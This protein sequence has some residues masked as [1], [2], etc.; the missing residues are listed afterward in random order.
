MGLSCGA[1]DAPAVEDPRLITEGLGSAA[2]R[3]VQERLAGPA[4]P[5]ERTLA[6]GDTVADFEVLD[7]PGHSAG[8]VAFFRSSDR[9][10]I[11]GDVLTNIDLRT[12]MPGLHEPPAPFTPDPPLNR[13]AARRLADLRPELA[14]FGHGA[15]LRD[16]GRFADYVSTLAT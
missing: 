3:A 6:E 11:L 1:R 7:T 10:L 5:V 2:M 4:H 8:H 9:T 14:L 15:P 12:G 16:P 13:D